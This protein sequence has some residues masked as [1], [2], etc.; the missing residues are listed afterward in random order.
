MIR[1][2]K[3]EF[4][5]EHKVFV[6]GSCW[7]WW[8]I[9]QFTC[10]CWEPS[11]L[12]VTV[13]DILKTTH[14][15]ETR[16]DWGGCFGCEAVCICC[17]FTWGLDCSEALGLWNAVKHMMMDYCVTA[18]IHIQL[19]RRQSHGFGGHGRLFFSSWKVCW[20]PAKVNWRKSRKRPAISGPLH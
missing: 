4:I 17:T 7:C 1:S 6:A 3:S 10:R 15:R 16:M 11:G 12:C 13:Q 2:H 9:V 19:D 20:K 5:P 18:R 8:S 14:T